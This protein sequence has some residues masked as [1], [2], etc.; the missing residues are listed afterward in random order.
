MATVEVSFTPLPANVRTVRLIATAVARRT[1]VEEPFLDEVRLAVGEACSRA[2]DE[3]RRHVPQEPIRL[4]MRDDGG[5]FE[6][7]VT[8]A[9]PSADVS[10]ADNP[11]PMRRDAADPGGP[12]AFLPPGVGLAVVAGLAD[13]VD[14]ASTPTGVRVRMSWPAKGGVHR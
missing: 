5:R 8:D 9:V 10:G 6:V 13:D 1:G 14:I 4:E 2:V 11:L 12:P 3:H 7:V